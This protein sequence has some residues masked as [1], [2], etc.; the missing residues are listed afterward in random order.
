MIVL[1]FLCFCI[2]G[3]CWFG[4][5]FVVGVGWRMLGYCSVFMF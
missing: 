3:G 5:G 4:G 2:G 1:F